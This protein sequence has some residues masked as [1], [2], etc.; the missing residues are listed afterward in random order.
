MSEVN[1]IKLNGDGTGEVH[2]QLSL[3]TV[4][5]KFDRHP[6]PMT[7]I[8]RVIYDAAPIP[9]DFH[10]L[11]PIM[12][13]YYASDG[14]FGTVVDV[15]VQLSIN[16]VI[17][18]ITEDKEVKAF[19]D[20]IVETSNLRSAI[21]SAFLE[22][23]LVSNV[24][25]YRTNH[26]RLVVAR[27]KKKVPLYE[28]T[29]LNPEYVH[30]SGTLLFGKPMIQLQPN[31]ELVNFV[32]DRKNKDLVQM[33]PKG[34]V[35]LISKGEN[36]D[37]DPDHVYHIARNKQPFQRYAPV[38][39][40]RAIRPLRIKE[41]FMQMDLSTADG[42]INQVVVFKLGSDKFP[43]TSDEP[44]KKFAQ[45]LQTPSKAYQLVWNHALDYFVIRSDAA[46]LD[47]KKYGPIDQELMY[48]FAVPEA[49][50]GG[51]TGSYGKDWLA[52]RGLVERLKWGIEDIESWLEREFRLIAEENNLP[53]W[54]K[55]KLG[56]I[57]LEEERTFK[58]IL[59]NL[60]DR[61]LLSGQTVIEQSGYEF[62]TEI[63]RLR[64][65]QKLREEE[66]LFVSNSP[67]QTPRRQPGRPE[68]SLDREPRDRRTPNP[69]P[70]GSGANASKS[71]LAIAVASEDKF[72]ESLEKIYYQEL[73]EMYKNTRQRLLAAIDEHEDRDDML[74][75]LLA[76]LG[77]FREE[78][79]DIGRR[80]LLESYRCHYESLVGADRIDER[81]FDKGVAFLV[82]WHSFYAD[83]FYH[84]FMLDIHTVVHDLADTSAIKN[85]VDAMMNKQHYR[86]ELF[87]NDGLKKARM[88]GQVY[89]NLQMGFT[90]GVWN[91]S[92]KN[93]CPECMERHGQTYPLDNILEIFPAHNRCNCW[94]EPT[95][96]MRSE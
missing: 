30:V 62:I 6:A 48:A 43:I 28:W 63:E 95:S 23:Y 29:V 34:F 3:G 21:R 53:T 15:Q 49:L 44:L 71:S 72:D 18:N 38:A 73:D 7:G 9:D 8:N 32:R 68:G 16:N 4:V 20:A 52:I 50:L 66:N 25:P 14:L 10:Q 83:K 87:A 76:I 69:L 84:Q 86:L 36:I 39:L 26:G 59:M 93:S 40:K 90:H 31:E 27:N 82:N 56:E 58:Q 61:G 78:L 12:R 2:V 77:S 80:R 37:L 47:P 88:T 67:Y 55:P 41:K 33:L 1:E 75:A 64:D 17:Q 70:S 5:N 91:C 60:Y 19:F 54:P 11:V 42:I 22:Y 51:R 96:I 24:F 94:I 85:F 79:E 92:F 46:A 13:H 81:E 74:Q 57:N 89:P 35:D 45:L 65:E